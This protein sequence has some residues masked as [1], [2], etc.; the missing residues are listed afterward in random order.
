MTRILCTGVECVNNVN[1]ECS[2]EQIQ[3]VNE[4]YRTEKLPN[5]KDVND[6][7][8]QMCQSFV[9]KKNTCKP[10]EDI[11]GTDELCKYCQHTNYGEDLDVKNITSTHS[12]CEG[13]GCKDA[14]E[15]YKEYK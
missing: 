15:T 2:A 4:E 13:T 9:W 1:G 5:N 14:Y 7:D 6:K 10:F 8:A 12:G 3:L 11:E